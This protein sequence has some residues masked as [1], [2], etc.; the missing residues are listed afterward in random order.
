[1]ESIINKSKRTRFESFLHLYIQILIDLEVNE[2]NSTRRLKAPPS[3]AEEGSVRCTFVFGHIVQ[4]VRYY[5]A[6]Q[7]FA[8][9]HGY[10][11]KVALE[12]APSAE[13]TPARAGEGVSHL[14]KVTFSTSQ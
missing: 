7:D 12:R 1:M 3:S 9:L 5:K 13:G 4:I 6:I 10:T 11:R 14:L 2:E 8:R